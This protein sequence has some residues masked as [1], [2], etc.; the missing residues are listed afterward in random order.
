MSRRPVPFRTVRR[1]A[2]VVGQAVWARID[3]LASTTEGRTALVIAAAIVFLRVPDLD[4]QLF[5]LLHHRSILT[6]SVLPVLLFALAGRPWSLAIATG[7]SLGVGA[8]LLA[9]AL[10]PMVGYGRVWWP[11][12][13]KS[14]LS[15][16]ASRLWLLS[17]GVLAFGLALRWADKA[18]PHRLTLPLVTG[19]GALAGGLYG[20]TNE[21]SL[22]AAALCLAVPFILWWLHPARRRR[23]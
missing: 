2:A 20:A 17:N 16:L 3:A 23:S 11:W 12:P 9:D 8:H 1:W 21:R 22:A 14:A 19:L 13:A 4:F 7:G 18:V 10:S 6:H 5:A 15:P